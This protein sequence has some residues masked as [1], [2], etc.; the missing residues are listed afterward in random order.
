MASTA[1]EPVTQSR[2]NFRSGLDLE[3]RLCDLLISRDHQQRRLCLE[4]FIIIPVSRFP[5][6]SRSLSLSPLDWDSSEKTL[7]NIGYIPT[8]RTQFVI[9]LA[10]WSFLVLFWWVLV[11]SPRENYE[12]RKDDNNWTKS[13]WYVAG[14]ARLVICSGSSI[15]LI[16]HIAHMRHVHTYIPRHN[17]RS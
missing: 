9:T 6:R 8:G 17:K 12:H 11:I 7:R 2:H 15:M 4:S 14:G 1:Q 5:A 3:R 10:S 13:V 16:A